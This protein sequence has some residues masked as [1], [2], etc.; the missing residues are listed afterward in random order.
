MLRIVAAVVHYRGISD[1]LA[2][3]ASLNTQ[4][5]TID[6][7]VVVD[8]ASDPG[9]PAAIRAAFPQVR[10]LENARNTGFAGGANRAIGDA[11]PRGADAVLLVNPDTR[12]AP[13]M[14]GRLAAFA[15]AEP[16]VGACGPLVLCAD[17]PQ[18]VWSAGGRVDPIGRA[19]H[20]ATGA[21]AADA[22]R[23]P[24]P[25]E[26]VAG[27]GLWLSRA[28]LEAA[29]P[30]DEAL[31][32]YYEDAD[33]CARIRRAGF[34]VWLEPRARMWHAGSRSTGVDSPA[35]AYYLCRNRLRFVGRYGG[36]RN[37]VAALADTARVAAAWSRRRDPRAPA[38]WRAIR[39]FLRGRGGAGPFAPPV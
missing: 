10:L 4:E 35:S 2:C 24:T 17:A 7:I 19:S 18:T 34:G 14:T 8:Q 38:G 9:A 22:P 1:T 25:V 31:F 36:F 15:A 23:A 26:Y 20:L 6:E 32:L 16:H 5:R 12:C 29:G 28:A 27:C 3:L 11:L 30:F 39:D 13:E 37:R 21:D 33:L